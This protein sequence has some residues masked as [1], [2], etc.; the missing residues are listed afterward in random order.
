MENTLNYSKLEKT[1]NP[2]QRFIGFM[3]YFSSKS[4]KKELA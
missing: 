2:L 3:C 4:A 1:T